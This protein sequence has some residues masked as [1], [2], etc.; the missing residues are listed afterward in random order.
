MSAYSTIVCPSVRSSFGSPAPAKRSTSASC[1][2]LRRLN[3]EIL[4]KAR[5]IRRPATPACRRGGPSDSRSDRRE[6]AL[7]LAIQE[8]HRSRHDKGDEREDQRVLGQGLSF[9][10]LDLSER[11]AL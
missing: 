10:A 9:F 2:S 3:M 8:D 5:V 7:D 11:G 1:I 4:L 6:Q